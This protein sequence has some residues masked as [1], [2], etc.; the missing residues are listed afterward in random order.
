MFCCITLS[1]SYD[2]IYIHQI[3]CKNYLDNICNEIKTHDFNKG[4]LLI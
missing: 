3:T 1:A 4:C 2:Y